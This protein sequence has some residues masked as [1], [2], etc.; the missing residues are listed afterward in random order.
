MKTTYI[1]DPNDA[2]QLA[3]SDAITNAKRILATLEAMPE[4]V[5]GWCNVG[6]MQHWNAQLQQLSDEIHH[7]GEFAE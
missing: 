4:T 6:S 7:E 2:W 1:H 5:K 3:R